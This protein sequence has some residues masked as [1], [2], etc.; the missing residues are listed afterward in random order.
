MKKFF[1]I[2]LCVILP[3]GFLFAGCSNNVSIKEMTE[4]YIIQ[5]WIAVP[6][7]SY[8]ISATGSS[9]TSSSKIHFIFNNAVSISEE[10]YNQKENSTI[11]NLEYDQFLSNYKSKDLAVDY[12]ESKVGKFRYYIG[13]DSNYYKA[14]VLGY[15]LTLYSVKIYSNNYLEVK[16]EVYYSRSNETVVLSYFGAHGEYYRVDFFRQG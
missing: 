2:L 1:I 3:V 13:G 14:E 9:S 15:E 7:V 4:N 5:D 6:S 11:E 10:E 8:P 12:A 16:L